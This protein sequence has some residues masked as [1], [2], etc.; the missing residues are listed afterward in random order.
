MHGMRKIPHLGG[1]QGLNSC[2]AGRFAH[3]SRA[4]DAKKAGEDPKALSRAGGG[5]ET[6][7]RLTIRAML[8]STLL[9]APGTFTTWSR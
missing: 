8:I 4:P 7:C 3:L 5:P 9:N 2:R 6:Y 1:T